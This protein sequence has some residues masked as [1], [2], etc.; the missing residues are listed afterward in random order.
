MSKPERGSLTTL[1]A[2]KPLGQGAPAAMPIEEAESALLGQPSHHTDH[3]DAEAYVRTSGR[4]DDEPRA[5]PAEA[6]PVFTEISPSV[7]PSVRTAIQPD[8]QP[9]KL[10][11]RSR[12]RTV[13]VP[14]TFKLPFELR[15]E[16]ESVARFNNLNMTE[17]AVEAIERHLKHFPHPTGRPASSADHD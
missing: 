11:N 12:R 13:R 15:E 5:I 2:K 17:I 14:W 1:L 3:T 4:S 10:L 7:Q 9:T 6:N 16:L 8:V